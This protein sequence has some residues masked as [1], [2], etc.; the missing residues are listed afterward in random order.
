MNLN[1]ILNYNH[2]N[3]D[4]STLINSYYSIENYNF[5]NEDKINEEIINKFNYKSE[6]PIINIIDDTFTNTNTN[7]NKGIVICDLSMANDDTFYDN[8]YKLSTNY[9]NIEF[10][11]YADKYIIKFNNQLTNTNISKSKEDF[12]N[13]LQSFF[14][15]RLDKLLLKQS[16]L[17]F[18]NILPEQ[19]N[20]KIEEDL[21]YIS[22][23]ILRSD[24]DIKNYIENIKMDLST[25][26]YKVSFVFADNTNNINTKIYNNI[27]EK[28]NKL[29]NYTNDIYDKI[30]SANNDSK[31]QEF[32]INDL[33]NL[34]KLK[35]LYTNNKTISEI[36]MN[37]VM[38]RQYEIYSD[39]SISVDNFYNN[40]F[41]F[42]NELVKRK[43]IKVIKIYN[44]KKLDKNL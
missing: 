23:D 1:T 36:R 31:N 2:S 4:I 16:I 20:A 29:N 24:E 32:L 37:D 25:D 7:I 40:I 44:K 26:N 13:K 18:P 9:S 34:S 41:K 19:F 35:T 5:T 43:I 10:N 15:N 28:L 22:K 17:N 30:N 8:L 21:S 14:A 27:L 38:D 6:L 3:S 12:K 39:K 33:F 42:L 11:H